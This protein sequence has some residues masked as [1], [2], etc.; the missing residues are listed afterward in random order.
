MT[1]K[2]IEN[3]YKEKYDDLV[4]MYSSR[5]GPDDVEDVVQEG[6]YRALKYIHTFNPTYITVERWMSG[7]LN[8]C[9]KDMLREK[10][11]G[12]AMHDT[13]HDPTTEDRCPSDVELE[14]KILTEIGKKVG[15]A[16]QILWLYFKMGYKNSDIHQIVGGSYTHVDNSTNDFKRDMRAKYGH[17]LV[18]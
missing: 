1:T 3:Y 2:L 5:A 8:N 11:D 6:F 15:A 10:R 16:R 17:L 18:D 4:R 9:L 13:D 7:I 14:E 12:A